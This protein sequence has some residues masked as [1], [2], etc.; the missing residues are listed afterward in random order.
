[1]KICVVGAG[2]IGGLLAAK[3]HKAGE[4]V[5]VVARG[6][7]LAAIRAN[8][9]TLV[10][11]GATICAGVAA[12][13]AIA[14]FGPQDLVILGM[15]AHQVSEVAAAVPRSRAGN[16]G[17]HRAER[18]SL[19]VFLQAWRPAG[20]ARLELRR[21]RRAH[22]RTSSGRKRHRQRHLSCRGNRGAGRDQP[23]RG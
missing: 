23:Y 4:D 2:A 9:L 10:E 20:G 1:M 14:D 22:R 15:K 19:V 7:H 3:L 12:S 21:S 11:E 17:P 18:H 6:A 16:A 8:G 5:S 13:D